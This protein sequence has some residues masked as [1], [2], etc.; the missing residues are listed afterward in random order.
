MGIKKLTRQW[1]NNVASFPSV[2]GVKNG[3]AH[4][5]IVTGEIEVPQ[6]DQ[7]RAMKNPSQYLE[8]KGWQWVKI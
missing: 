3:F 6:K 4:D 1:T 8:S 7:Q 5:L 2:Y